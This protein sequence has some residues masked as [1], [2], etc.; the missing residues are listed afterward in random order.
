MTNALD[1]F[2]Q[3][4]FRS[5]GDP[6]QPLTQAA[7]ESILNL[8][9]TDAPSSYVSEYG[10]IVSPKAK[11]RIGHWEDFSGFAGTTSGGVVN[12]NRYRIF[13]STAL[14][15]FVMDTTTGKTY[16][17]TGNQTAVLGNSGIFVGDGNVNLKL[18][19]AENPWMKFLLSQNTAPV[20]GTQEAVAGLWND[21]VTI[22]ATMD[23]GIYF[24]STNGGNW[25]LVCRSTTTTSVDLGIA[26][27]ST[28]I[29]LEF[30]VS[31]DGGKVQAYYNNA[32][33]GA[34]ITSNIP[35]G[36]LFPTVLHYNRVLT[37]TT[38]EIIRCY[39]F[40]WQQDLL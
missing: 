20:G 33:V 4:E 8:P 12:V 2:H 9:P 1:R 28:L 30:R 35:T 11:Q 29:L 38:A 22:D 24:S 10:S 34:A 6:G 3:Q 37:V 16:F 25:F 31:N 32:A 15:A 14:T 13:S 5:P 19:A 21:V 18:R 23:D 36:L 40:G 7:L 17:I 26:P 27:S 39:G